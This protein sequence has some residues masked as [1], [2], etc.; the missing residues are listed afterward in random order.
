MGFCVWE[1]THIESSYDRLEN[2]EDSRWNKGGHLGVAELS[3]NKFIKV[4]KRWKKGKQ[5]KD[6]ESFKM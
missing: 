3:W 4:E 1:P 5:Q 2:V 6:W